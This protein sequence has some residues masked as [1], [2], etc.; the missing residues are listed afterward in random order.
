[1]ITKILASRTPS[2]YMDVCKQTIRQALLTL[3]DLT[4]RWRRNART[5]KALAK[6]SS[7]LYQDIG[8]TEQ[9]IRHELKKKFWQ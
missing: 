2:Q 3:R 5:R 8:L 9:Q 4:R 1:M 6:L 7:H